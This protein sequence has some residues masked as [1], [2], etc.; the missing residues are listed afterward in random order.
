MLKNIIF[1]L[2]ESYFDFVKNYMGALEQK[3]SS[4]DVLIRAERMLPPY[5]GSANPQPLTTEIIRT[6]TDSYPACNSLFITDDP[7]TF[8]LLSQAGFYTIALYH[9]KNKDCSFPG[10]LYAVENIRELEYRSY[11][12]AYRRLA[13]IPW[14]ILETDRLLVREST[15]D[16]IPDF[17]RIY[18][19]TS[20]TDHMEP[21]FED[22]L[23]E[24]AY[25]QDYIRQVYGF[26]GFGI[27]T[28]ILKETGHIIGRAGLNIRE[29]Y[30]L[31]E[32]G[33][34]IETALQ[35]QG[36]AF[37]VC[38]AILVYAKKELAFDRLQAFVKKENTASKKL[39]EKLGFSYNRDA[40]EN[41]REYLLY[42]AE[43]K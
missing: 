14:N 34:V 6:L 1:V 25:L 41:G 22:P 28:V 31:P 32:L 3:V 40:L 36:L 30:D 19:G 23:E 8:C 26:Y 7:K 12:E 2:S 17:Y 21:L 24:K 38:S 35:N 5:R 20:I 13:G 29:G 10:A 16:D 37:E 4:Y 33:F 43:L 15:L 42:T 11:D 27:W 9:E 18:Q 39:L